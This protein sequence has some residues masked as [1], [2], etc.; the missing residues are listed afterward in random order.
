VIE[1]LFSSSSPSTFTAPSFT[2][3]AEECTLT[4]SNFFEL[5]L[6]L[7]PTPSPPPPAAPSARRQF[8]HT[9]E[10]D[11]HFAWPVFDMAALEHSAEG[12]FK[13][14]E[15]ERATAEVKTEID[16]EFEQQ[17]Q[18]Q[19]QQ[20]QITATATDKVDLDSVLIVINLPSTAAATT[21]ITSQMFKMIGTV[22]RV[23]FPLSSPTV[24]FVEFSDWR[25]ARLAEG[26]F[27]ACA[28]GKG[29]FYWGVDGAETKGEL[30][31]DLTGRRFKHYASSSSN[32]LS[33]EVEVEVE[34]DGND[35][36][37]DTDTDINNDINNDNHN[38]EEFFEPFDVDKAL[39]EALAPL[40]Q[41]EEIKVRFLRFA[42]LLPLF[43]TKTN[44]NHADLER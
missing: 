30:R 8:L 33:M 39:K 38:E 5:L 19:Q 28:K 43:H 7:N 25:E 31:G 9:A 21:L 23:Y 2:T 40:D 22:R 36:D 16:T 14:W 12:K 3:T 6:S 29:G 24:A 18:Q 4:Y 34:V 32:E 15:E 10:L 20:K 44:P 42:F 17:Q 35:T 1:E 11:A 26:G 27:L 41:Y 37:T 13:V